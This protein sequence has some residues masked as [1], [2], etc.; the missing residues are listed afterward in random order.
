M[1]ADQ[2]KY[3]FI[4]IHC[5]RQSDF[6]LPL[7]ALK[8]LFAAVAL[9]NPERPRVFSNKKL[10]VMLSKRFCMYCYRFLGLFSFNDYF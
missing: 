1:L 6:N 7:K 5:T 8:W 4:F 3:G 10:N 9:H 2:T